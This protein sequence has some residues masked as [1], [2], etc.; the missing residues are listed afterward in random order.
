MDNQLIISSEHLP[1]A[2]DCL[3]PLSVLLFNPYNSTGRWLLLLSC[4]WMR[5]Q[6]HREGK[7]LVPGCRAG[8]RGWSQAVWPQSPCSCWLALQPLG[9]V[10][11]LTRCGWGTEASIDGVKGPALTCLRA[12]VTTPPWE[13]RNPSW[14]WLPILLASLLPLRG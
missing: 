10:L 2:W 11:R 12:P 4:L 14:D 9:K 5:K 6:R 7:Q 8:P 1:R 3:K 13:G